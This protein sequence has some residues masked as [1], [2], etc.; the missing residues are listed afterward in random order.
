MRHRFLLSLSVT[1]VAIA[2]LAAVSVMAQAP[3]SAKATASGRALPR[4]AWGAPD[5]QGVWDFRTVTPLERPKDLSGKAVLND[6]EAAEFEQQQNVRNNRDTNVPAGNVGDYNEFWYDRGKRI[7]GAKRTSLIIDPPDGRIP[8][9]TAEA[10]KKRDALAEKRRGVEMDVPTPGGFVQDLGPGGLR[11]RCILGFNAGPPMSPSAYNNNVQLFQTPNH[12]VILNEMI[13]DARIV[14][15]DGRPHGTLRQWAGDS[16]GRWDGNTLV[17]DTV[18]FKEPPLM[19]TGVLSET[20]HLVERFTRVDA[21]TLLYEYTIEDPKTWTKPWTVQM[22]MAKN[23]E[24]MYEYACHE[25][26]YGLYNILSGAQKRDEAA[27]KKG[28]R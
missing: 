17:V 2:V 1:A 11:V 14:P 26:N 8:P 12:V 23:S 7:L 4:T 15:L 18:N 19:T 22:Y 3:K 27:A 9:L 24:S 5:L 13:H 25:G 6:V 20:M 16:R 10:Q 28:S 21:D